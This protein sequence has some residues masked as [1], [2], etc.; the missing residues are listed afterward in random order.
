MTIFKQAC[1]Y[2]Y[3]AYT[4]QAHRAGKQSR[5]CQCSMG[6]SQARYKKKQRS[7][8]AIPKERVPS[9]VQEI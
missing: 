2:I 4:I 3:Q 8:I 6:I 5:H 7:D 1:M 9:K